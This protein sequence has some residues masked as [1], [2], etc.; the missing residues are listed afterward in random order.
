MN[1]LGIIPARGGSK[2][3][4]KKNIYPL[5]GKPLISYVLTEALKSKLLSKVVVSSDD[6]EILNVAEQYGGKDILLRR[7]KE[8]AEDITPDVPMLQHAVDAMEK[9]MK[10]TFDYIVQLHATTPLLTHED[11]DG[12]IQLLLDS[13]DADSSVSV[14]KISDFKPAKIKKIINNRLMQYFKNTEEKTTSR[15]QDAEPAYKRNAGIYVAKRF[16]IMDEGRVWGEHCL[17]YVMPHERSIDINSRFDFVI[18]EAALK[19]LKN[20][21]LK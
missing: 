17:A 13:P 12:C 11:I 3:V 15:R 6:D 20:N 4:P 8:L 16:V 9:K 10:T 2:S 14:Y 19:H 5:G 1:I 7:P 18:A 21:N